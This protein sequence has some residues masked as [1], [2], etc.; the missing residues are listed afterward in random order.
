VVYSDPDRTDDV[1]SRTTDSSGQATC[2][3]PDGTYYYTAAR[4]SYGDLPGDFTVSGG[5]LTESFD[6]VPVLYTVTFNETNGLE[7]VSIVVYSDPGRTDDIVSRT[8][9]SSGK[10]TCTLPDGTYYYRATKASYANRLGDFTVSGGPL[11]ESFEMVPVLYTVTFN[12]TNGLEGVSIVVYSDPGRTDNI[13]SRTTDSS[14]QATCTLPDGTYY[15]T[16]AR[17]SYGDLPGVFTVS[18]GPLTESFEMVTSNI[19]FTVF[20]EDFTG[21]AGGNLPSGWARNSSL[22]RV[23]NSNHALGSVPELGLGCGPG[24]DVYLDYYVATPSIDATTTSSALNL[25]FKSYFS[26]YGDNAA[27]PYTYAVETSDNYGATWTTVLQESPTLATYPM[28]HFQRTE[29]IDISACV[30]QTIMIRW[31]LYGYTWWMNAWHIDDIMVT[32]S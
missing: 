26:L 21:I 6:M 12:E 17:A 10:A 16:A 13:A 32:G 19:T 24:D 2:T 31:R 3:L 30:G 28:G 7:G 20:A 27:Y 22:C 18:G 14:G 1:V 4:A 11:T 8:T 29:S 23:Y 25:S 5:P 15:Y 9:R